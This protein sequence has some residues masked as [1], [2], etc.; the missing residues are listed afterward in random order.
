M[1]TVY[2]WY[3][4]VPLY[5][6]PFDVNALRNYL[7]SRYGSLKRGKDA[8]RREYRCFLSENAIWRRVLATHI[9][10]Y[11]EPPAKPTLVLSVVMFRGTNPEFDYVSYLQ[12]KGVDINPYTSPE[13]LCFG[14]YCKH[15]FSILD[16]IL[17]ELAEKHLIRD[18]MIVNSIWYAKLDRR[19]NLRRLAETGLFVPSFS[20]TFKLVTGI[21]EYSKVAIFYTGTIR[22]MRALTPEQAMDVLGRVYALMLKH[23]A[24]E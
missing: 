9:D 16:E 15:D 5:L 21:V 20:N 13:N 4:D 12:S 19:V 11:V 6:Y 10:D 22:I 14:F 24:L 7:L 18:A 2:K 17:G 3:G 23:G 1:F 8:L